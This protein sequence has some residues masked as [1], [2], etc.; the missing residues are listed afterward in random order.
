VI[1]DMC[2]AAEAHDFLEWLRLR[3]ISVSPPPSEKERAEHNSE[4]LRAA[5][6]LNEKEPPA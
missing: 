3:N 5:G 4:A 2:A 1:D 6:L